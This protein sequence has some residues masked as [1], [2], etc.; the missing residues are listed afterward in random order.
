MVFRA[1]EE[2]IRNLGNAT[3]ITQ[4]MDSRLPRRTPATMLY[5]AMSYLEG[6]ARDSTEYSKRHF[7]ALALLST[8]IPLAYFVDIY[9]GRPAFDTLPLRLSACVLV[10][11]LFF[12]DTLFFARRINYNLYFVCMATYVLPFLFGVMLVMN[13]ALSPPGVEIEMLWVLQY[14]VSLFLFIQVI[15]NGYLST[16]L[17]L[18]AS[19]CALVPLAWIQNPN[20]EEL[21]RVIV[22]P[23]TCYL[24]ALVFG[25]VTNR[26]ADYI[27]SEKL[28]AASAIGSY[29]AHELR[30]PLASI[31]AIARA[32]HKH[33]KTMCDGYAA[34]VEAGLIEPTIPQSKARDLSESLLLMQEEVQYSNTIIDM[35]LLNIK[36]RLELR[37]HP[38]AFSASDAILESIRRF[39]FSN[40][41]ERHRVSVNIRQ[42]FEIHA[43]R[44]LIIHV[45]FNL[46]KNGVYYMQRSRG[47]YVLVSTGRIG[48]KH[49]IEVK[50]TGPGIPRDMRKRIFDRF[51]TTTEAGQGAGIGLSFCKMVMEGIGGEIV[52]DSKEG[53]YTTFRLLF[54]EVS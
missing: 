34:A 18:I 31:A 6:A 51:F 11:P 21:T 39:P 8:C 28:K 44:L 5:R 50:D 20:V 41:D 25:I 9:V 43:S 54:P 22:Y 47:G 27:N 19:A 48:R 2:R 36:D 17:W 45:L 23:V 7:R 30:T 13:A 32:N 37:G 1:R 3:Q 33:V 26:N 52:C 12:Y 46:L 49:Y 38:E 10:L 24:T 35:L 42:D 14:F 16:L 53:E 4:H 29:I 15:H 40:S